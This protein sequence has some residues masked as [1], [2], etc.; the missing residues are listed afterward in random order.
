MLINYIWQSI[1]I[2]SGSCICYMLN[3]KEYEIEHEHEYEHASSCLIQ[4]A[5]PYRAIPKNTWHTYS[6]AHAPSKKMQSTCYWKSCEI[7][8]TWGTSQGLGCTWCTWLML[9]CYPSSRQLGLQVCATRNP[10]SQAWTTQFCRAFHSVV[11]EPHY[12]SKPLMSDAVTYVQYLQRLHPSA[13]EHNLNPCQLL[14]PWTY[15]RA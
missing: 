14:Q 8:S 9:I 6:R 15:Q 2:G 7:A 13:L 11:R 3:I 5:P 10:L 12:L 1:W 4:Y